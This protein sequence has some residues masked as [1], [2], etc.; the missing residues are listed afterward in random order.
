MARAL[1]RALGLPVIELDAI[2]WQAG[3]RDLDTHDPEAFVQ[4]RS[5]RPPG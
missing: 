5:P 3:W 2:N 1:G 4:L